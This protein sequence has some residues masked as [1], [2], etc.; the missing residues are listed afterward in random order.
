VVES[1]LGRDLSVTPCLF[2]ERRPRL[3]LDPSRQACVEPASRP[4]W[5]PRREALPALER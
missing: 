2:G 3:P 1:T 4:R 5:K